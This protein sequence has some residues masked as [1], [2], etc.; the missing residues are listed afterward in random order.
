VDQLRLR[1][2]LRLAAITDWLDGWIARRYELHSAFGHSW[3]RWPTS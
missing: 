3:T 2:D 1:G